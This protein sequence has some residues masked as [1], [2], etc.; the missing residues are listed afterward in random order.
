MRMSMEP[1]HLSVFRQSDGVHIGVVE[2]QLLNDADGLLD[3]LVKVPGK[4]LGDLR[5][6]GI[7]KDISG[8]PQGEPP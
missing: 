8:V 3:V 7:L 6:A 5:V 4:M 1:M 2:E